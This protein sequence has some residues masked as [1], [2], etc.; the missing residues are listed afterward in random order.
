MKCV[1]TGAAGFVGSSIID[2]L[3]SQGH[4]VAGIDCFVDYYPKEYKLRNLEKARSHDNFRFLEANLLALDLKELLAGSQWIFH[5]AAQAG[6]RASWGESF[7]IYTDNNILATQRLLEACLDESVKES[8]EKVVYASS[9]SVY[10]SAETLPTTEKT[11]PRPVSP[12]GVSKLAAE[13]LMVLYATE[14]GLPTASLRYF[15]V[16]GPRQRPDMAFRKFITA[17]LKGETLTVYGDGEQSRDFTFI[18]DIVT[19]NIAAA[20]SKTKELVFNIGGGSRVTVNEVLAKLRAIINTDF[21]VDYKPTAI[22]DA[23]H[24]GADT[25][26]AKKELSFATTV[27]VEEGLRREAEWLERWLEPQANSCAL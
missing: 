13:H 6:V 18:E 9:S 17:A 1:V 16:Y 2:R 15:T 21:S 10:G 5:Q 12:Y 4:E 23:R 26:L 14:F 24:T 7:S 8:L 22:G 19:A 3:L 25:S 27:S 11:L 20:S